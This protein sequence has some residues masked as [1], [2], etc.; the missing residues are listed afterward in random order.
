MRRVYWL[1]TAGL[2]LV[3]A[4]GLAY[5]QISSL[6]NAT[7]PLTGNET[8]AIDQAQGINM[9]TV[10]TTINQVRQPPTPV[11]IP[12]GTVLGNLGLTN[13]APTAVP[14]PF[15]RVPDNATLKQRPTTFASMIVRDDFSVNF[16]AGPLI[17]RA[18]TTACPGNA[19][20]DDGGYVA[21]SDGKCWQAVFQDVWASV[22]Q[23]GV[24]MTGNAVSTAA[25][26]RAVNWQ[27]DNVARCLL[28]PSGLVK[29]DNEI[30]F[31]KERAC[32]SG[33][34]QYIST[35]ITTNANANMFRFGQGLVHPTYLFGATIKKLRMIGTGFNVA[36][37]GAALS[38]GRY[39][40]ID[41][42]DVR[43]SGTFDGIVEV[44]AGVMRVTKTDLAHHKRHGIL[45][46][47]D[48]ATQTFDYGNP[49]V[50]INNVTQFQDPLTEVPLGANIY[51]RAIGELHINSSALGSGE[52]CIELQP[53]P[54]MKVLDVFVDN[55][56]CDIPYRVGL[57][58]NSSNPGSLVSEIT[59][60]GGRISHTQTGPAVAINGPQSY[61]ISMTGAMLSRSAVAN[62]II[63]NGRGLKFDSVQSLS[64]N[65]MQAGVGGNNIDIHGGDK[66]S[67]NNLLLDGW[68]NEGFTNT[69]YGVV[70]GD[71]FAGSIDVVGS[72]LCG[73]TINGIF[74]LSTS[75][76]INF[77]K[78]QCV[79]PLEAGHVSEYISSIAI[80]AGT[81]NATF[82]H[83][84]PTSPWSVMISPTLPA[85]NYGVSWD[86]TSITISSDTPVASDT[87][88]YFSGVLNGSP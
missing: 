43:M 22:A 24:D 34:D 69:L 16:G 53:G 5:A 25:L 63:F 54:N 19:A 86:N 2:V 13:A 46:D 11:P 3:G 83:N 47:S 76:N 27:G 65:V 14:L 12:P 56:N 6:P 70:V 59:W 35:I 74:N 18:M 45:L 31:N 30:L 21:S 42:E 77:A 15:P 75:R 50:F 57:D 62:I 33:I 55:T 28:V 20:G 87:R 23:W 32:I 52:T 66:I 68:W 67:F 44:D 49:N 17:Y 88:V 41:I 7:T 80:P 60:S 78:N 58:I 51:A 85:Y 1:S 8:L 82:N 38:F 4:A 39:A 79:D 10:K 37:S 61:N 81:T 36:Q 9:R 71:T 84:F 64:A 29:I 26:Q 73:A 48:P 72:N 40:D